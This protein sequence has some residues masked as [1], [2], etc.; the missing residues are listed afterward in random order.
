QRIITATAGAPAFAQRSPHVLINFG[1]SHGYAHGAREMAHVCFEPHIDGIFSID[2]TKDDLSVEPANSY[3]ALMWR[4]TGGRFSTS[5]YER[6]KRSQAVASFCGELI[7]PMPFKNP[8]CYLVGGTKAKIRRLLYEAI[9]RL[10]WRPR[11]TVQ[12][13]SFR[14]WEALCAG[15]LVF[16][17]DLHYYGAELPVMPENWKHYIGLR[18]D[19]RDNSL[20]RLIAEWHR[21]PD[22]AD[23]GHQWALLNYSPKAMA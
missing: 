23:A 12:W 13:D 9:S 17:L 21:L 22:I 15:C 3:E 5:Y 8:E 14:F 19:K 4:Q 16:N 18:L 7:P 6:L 20:D 1:A 10:D 11:R 2:R